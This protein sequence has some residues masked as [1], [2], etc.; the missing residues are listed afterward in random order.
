MMH[1]VVILG[2]VVAH[3]LLTWVIAVTHNLLCFLAQQPK[4]SHIHCTGLLLLD[5]V[6]ENSNGGKVINMN[7]RGGLGGP[8]S[9]RVSLIIFASMVLKNSTPSSAWAA[10]ATTHLRIVQLVRMAPLR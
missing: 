6:V 5:C 2:L 9:S 3:V 7:L 4:I 10:L 1:P 8:I